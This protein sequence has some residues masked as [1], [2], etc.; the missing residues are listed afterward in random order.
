MICKYCD[1][2]DFEN[3]KGLSV[4]RRHNR[5]CYNKWLIEKQ[6]EENKKT[7]VQ[8]LLCGIQ[9]RNISNTHL[10]KHSI[11]QKQY[12]TLFPNALLFSDG[13]LDDQKQ[14]REDTI[15]K[16]YTKTEIK[17]LK[18]EKSVLAREKKHNMKFSKICK[19]VLT[20]DKKRNPEK[21]TKIYGEIGEKVK[22]F[23]EKMSD[24]IKKEFND[25]KLSKRKQTNLKKYGVE[26]V[27]CLESTKNKIKKTKKERYGDENFV[28]VEKCK[29]T[30]FK[31]YGKY[32]NFFPHFSILS[33]KLF[34]NIE[35]NLK[36]IKCQY[37]INGNVNENNEFQ[38]LIGKKLVRFLDFYIPS[39][40]KWIEFDEKYHKYDSI[41]K[42]DKRRE[43][44][45]CSKIKGVKL[46][47]ITKEEFIQ[48]KNKAMQK[49]L[50]F[51]NG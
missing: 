9:F 51:I 1:R 27:Q 30:L 19:N 21:Y 28:N 22:K 6:E 37:A 39:L 12:K 11:T 25:K 29:K 20:E 4:H 32:S 50:K 18:G 16:K 40:K 44:Q 36:N 14:K 38:V 5:K 41:S 47:R 49:C 2:E 23:H 13:L 43:K 17:Y 48:D 34:K 15:K 35:N 45:I 24:N 46:L 10:K 3:N 8:C 26:F 31:N 42:Q 7:K 33:Q